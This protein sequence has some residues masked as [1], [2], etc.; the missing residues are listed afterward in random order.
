[1]EVSEDEDEVGK[2]DSSNKLHLM[3]I[4]DNLRSDSKGLTYEDEKESEL[5][6]EEHSE[7]GDTSK[8]KSKEEY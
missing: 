5:V 1:M 6:N 7:T 2:K 3:S 8:K 4:S